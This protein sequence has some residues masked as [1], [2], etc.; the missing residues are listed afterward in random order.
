MST[1]LSKYT[2]AQN[3]AASDAIINDSNSPFTFKEWIERN[4]GVLPGKE[5]LQYEN[6]VKQWYAN[7]TEEVPTSTSVKED[8]INLLKQLTIA[9]KSEADVLQV[10]NINFDDPDEIEQVIPFYAT[11]LKEIAIYLINKRE[12]IRRAKL[13]YN[14]TGTYSAL[15]RIFYEYLLKAFT[16]RQFPGNEYITNITDVSVFNNVPE[17]S[18]VRNNFQIIVEELYDDASYFDRDPGLSASAYFTFDSNVT[19]Y[20]DTLN[21]SPSAYEWLYSTGVS[22]LCADNPLLWSVDSVLNQYKN[23]IPLSAV[24]LYDSDVLNDYNRIKLSQKYIGE[25][26]FIL[27]GGY[28]IPWI[29]NISFNFV[30]GNNWFYWLSGENIFENDTSMIIDPL[31]LSGTNLIESGATAGKTI[32]AADII[33][34]NRN[35][36]LSGAWLNLV[37]T[38]SFTTDMSAK[39]SKGKN[40]FAFPFPGYGLSGEDLTWTGKTLDNLSQTFFYLEKE[41]QQA[42][43]NAYWNSSLSSVSSFN[44]LHVNDTSLIEAGAY[45]SDRFNN[46]DYIITRASFRDGTTDYIFT[47]EQEYAWLYKMVKTD[48]PIRIGDTHI[49]WPLERYDTNISMQVS[50]NQCIPIY[51]S[52]IDIRNFVGAIANNSFDMADKIYKHTSP[53]ATTY[54]EAAWLS[55]KILPQPQAITST[56]ISSGC[57]QPGLAMRIAGGNYGSFIWTDPTVFADAVFKN[58]QHQDDCW[59]LKNSQF[60]LYKEKPTQNRNFNYNQWQD[61]SCR[62]IV[63]SPLGHPGDIFDHYDGMADFIIAVTSP[64]ASFSFKDWRGMDG[65]SYKESSEFG[66]FKLDEIYKIEPDVGWGS[67]SWITN[68]GN[69]F[70]LSAN[71]MYLY[72][73]RDMYRDEPSVN[74]PY[75][76]IK[77]KN[78]VTNNTWVK[79]VYNKDTDT[80]I[81]SNV[82][83]DMIINPGDML[84]YVHNGTYSFT[85]TSSH[86]EFSTQEVPILPNFNNL[87]INSTL[88]ETNLPIS[89]ISVP[90]QVIG[91]GSST[92]AVSL[93]TTGSVDASYYGFPNGEISLSMSFSN[94][95]STTTTTIMST[96]TTT[97]IDYYI[98][99]NES[100]NFILNVPL[101]G[102][103]YTN[104]VFDGFS[105]GARPIWVVASDLE[106]GYTKQKNIDIWAG[107]PIIVDDY[108]FITQPAYSNII[109]KNNSYIEYNKRNTGTIIW[110]QPINVNVDIQDKKWCKI[111]IDTNK[112]SNLSSVL[113]NNI[114]DL[115]V[116]AT[117]IPSDIILNVVQDEPLVIN[118]YARNEFTWTQDISNSSLGIPPTGGIWIP[119]ETGEL[120]TPL[121]PYAHLS[122][123]HYPTYASAPSVGDLYTTKDSGGYMIPK[124]FGVSTA[125]SKNNANSLNTSN[126]NNDPTKRSTTVIYGE[127]NHYTSDRGLSKNDQIAPITSIDIDARWMKASITE[128][129]KAGI[130]VNAR[131]HQEF[132]P[133]QTQYEN[134]G[135]N[136]NG[137]F[138][139]GNDTYDP[140]FGDLDIT[141]ENEIEWPPNSRQQYDIAGWYNQHNMDD[142][143]VY[144]W[145]TDIFGNQYALLK[146][147][148][149]NYS[150]YDKK[151]TCTGSMWTRNMRN[152]IEPASAS[153]AEVFAVEGTNTISNSLSSILDIDIWFDTMM[154]YTSSMIYFFHLNFDYDTGVISSNTDEVNYINTENSKFGGIWFHE[155]DKKI[156]VCTLLS[157]QDQI[158][159]I[160]RSLN[161]ETNQLTLLYNRESIYTNTSAFNFISY[162]H[163]VFTY[164]YN[165]KIYNISYIS[166]TDTKNGM[167]LNTINIRDTGDLYDIVSSKTIIPNA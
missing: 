116:S 29:N 112:I 143:Q 76:I 108:N 98:Y 72:F 31:Y 149:S 129:Q 32:T 85:L 65:K 22:Q 127:L 69:P 7:K 86:Y 50:A 123:R 93:S 30:G 126:I 137:L 118:Y 106:N 144:Q 97:L 39:M 150:I 147:D 124:L 25:P 102:W 132:M 146:P 96:I 9:F 145:K 48:I 162:D 141:W 148:L 81:D 16:K 167:Y 71:T 117:N 113:F 166:Y 54:V 73:R 45:A 10:S 6:Y 42:V 156:T 53:N 99:T 135:I 131:Q 17:L 63:Y 67:G 24:E 46:A 60:S 159:P 21:I 41:Y 163:P 105:Q 88:G 157:C 107:T 109:F 80:W 75:L 142:K 115:V 121:I 87:S 155:E 49:Y 161:L 58:I 62:S 18:A 122:N 66:W 138:R 70:M 100:I 153:L 111:L 158:R 40:I 165:T 160:L 4:V 55:G 26:R 2:Q 11:K 19:S 120:V 130:I 38:F 110:K 5:V 13:K 139:Q 36:L 94:P 89:S 95:L 114:N 1:K 3:I 34:I 134:K 57:Y 83:S 82:V 84:Y 12:A 151:H 27:S 14:M 128:G 90:V 52:S 47:D 140:W 23:G 77:Y 15:E 119:I 61:C 152:I 33:F 68:T 104:S 43:Y 101:S 133:Y 59:Y 92:S 35:N 28:W 51:L 125:V 79:M 74:V 44:E 8:Y 91:N 78:T 136:D 56:N 103:D 20:L 154:I 37:D 64:S 164:D